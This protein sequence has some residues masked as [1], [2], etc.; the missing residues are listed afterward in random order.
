MKMQLLDGSLFCSDHLFPVILGLLGAALLGWLLKHFMGNNAST[1]SDLQAKYDRLSADFHTERERNNKLVADSKKKK[2]NNNDAMAMGTAAVAGAVA[3]NTKEVENLQNKLKAV[4]TE[5]SAANEN[6]LKLTAEANE[7]K[8][9]AK[10]ATTLNSEV[11]T[12]KM[13]V[14]GLNKALET[15]KAEAE[16]Y[17]T[18][19]ENANGER[20]R[21]SAQ[22]ASSDLGEMQR[23]IERL[24]SNLDTSRMQVASLQSE[25]NL[26]KNG[27]K[28]IGSM[29]ET[30]QDNSNLADQLKDT[31]EELEKIK[32]SNARMAKEI[33]TANL[34]TNVAVN[35]ATAKSNKEVSELRSKIRMAEGN[36]AK[37]EADLISALSIK[38]TPS[39]EAVKP[40]EPAVMQTPMVEE[41]P[42]EPVVVEKEIE[43]VVETP[44]EEE[45]LPEP[46]IEESKPEVV[47]EKLE[48]VVIETPVVE[49]KPVNN[50]FKEIENDDLKV[51]EGVGPVL[52]KTLN[53]GGIYTYAQIANSSATTL[54]DIL[55]E[56]GDK[57]HDPTSWPMQAQL[58]VDGKMDEFKELCDRLKGG[59]IVD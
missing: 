14:E 49:E 23:K 17:K 51:L 7:A 42:A 27:A 2:S 12:L 11:E 6:A 44:V 39:V 53:N 24:E 48:H 18:E 35:D 47:I 5:L 55:L 20:S 38:S 4:K 25:L 45:K 13:R 57:L 9:K 30:K 34:K 10:E 1:S 43:P 56:A 28:T 3:T 22:L 33:E 50:G 58:L 32:I 36:I 59:R 8:L 37:L 15:N 41:K 21:L 19:F 46:I 29:V 40:I 16:K 54:K 26:A 31:K 52:E